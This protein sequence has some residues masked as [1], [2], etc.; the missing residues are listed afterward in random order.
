MLHAIR[1]MG[2]DHVGLGADWDGGGGV[3]GMEDITALPRISAR[4]RREGLSERDIAKIMGGNLLRVMRQVQAGAAPALRRFLPIAPR[5]GCRRG[6][7]WTGVARAR[8]IAS[9]PARSRAA[10]RLSGAPGGA[11]RHDWAATPF[12]PVESWPQSLTH[13]RLDGARL[14]P[15][16]VHRLGPGFPAALQ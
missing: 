3:I 12:G 7:C 14:D 10:A 2:V 1:V 5:L 13:R 15:A 6:G 4:L 16:D 9:R 11:E 8:W